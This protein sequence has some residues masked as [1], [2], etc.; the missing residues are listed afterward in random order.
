MLER[1]RNLFSRLWSFL[2]RGFR[3]F[4]TRGFWSLSSSTRLQSLLFTRQLWTFI[5]VYSTLVTVIHSIFS[6]DL[7]S[8]RFS[9]DN[10]QFRRKHA[11]SAPACQRR[12]VN[13]D[14]GDGSAPSPSEVPPSLDLIVAPVDLTQ[15]I[16][17]FRLFFDAPGL[18]AMHQD[19]DKID[20]VDA[21]YSGRR[22][23]AFVARKNA[24]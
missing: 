20:F 4:V 24:G 17:K 23:T 12:T 19:D 18:I 11:S 10:Y 2:T 8:I 14:D 22:D 21:C 15:H 9:S 1:R 6:D 7:R 13:G 16:D 3:S 5:I